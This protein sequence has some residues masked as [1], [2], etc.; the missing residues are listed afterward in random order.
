MLNIYNCTSMLWLHISVF[1][2][3]NHFRPFLCL[4]SSASA[5]WY[6]CLYFC[7]VA[8]H[9]VVWDVILKINN[10][11][12]YPVVYYLSYCTIQIWLV[13]RTNWGPG[14][15]GRASGLGEHALRRRCC[16]LLIRKKRSCLEPI[17]PLFTGQK[18][19]LGFNTACLYLAMETACQA[20]PPF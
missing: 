19:G 1:S 7:F 10:S 11:M 17:K 8:L 4:K 15:L 9:F 16:Q 13:A 6:T 20:F 18:F 2:F 12:T 5:L 3:F 14:G